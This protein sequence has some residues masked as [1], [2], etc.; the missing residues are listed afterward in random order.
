MELF[1]RKN[2]IEIAWSLCVYMC[3]CVHIHMEAKQISVVFLLFL[4]GDVCYH[5][6][7]FT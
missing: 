7:L 4:G 5:V 6:L 1:F 3:A 2:N